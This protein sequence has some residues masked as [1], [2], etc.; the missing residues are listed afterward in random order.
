MSQQRLSEQMIVGASD[1]RSKLLSQQRFSEQM[2]AAAMIVAAND[3]RSN[4]C[5]SK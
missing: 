4:D 2:K 1:C 5:R 3:C